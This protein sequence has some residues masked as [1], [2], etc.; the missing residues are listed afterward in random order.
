MGNLKDSINLGIQNDAKE[1]EFLE[2]G[3]KRAKCTYKS[4]N[5]FA[6]YLASSQNQYLWLTQDINQAA[7]VKWTFD[8][9]GGRWLEKSTVPYDRFLGVA[10]YDYADWGLSQTRGASKYASPVIYNTDHTISLASD[11]RKFLYG[12]Y[13]DQWVCWG[14]NENVLVVNFVD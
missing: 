3:Y 8:S 1:M 2:A 14:D 7:W 6:G 5:E 4:N 12:P 13:G 11:P 9:I 10:E